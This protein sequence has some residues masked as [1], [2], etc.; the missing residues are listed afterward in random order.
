[1][2]AAVRWLC[3]KA[4]PGVQHPTGLLLLGVIT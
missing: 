4:V 2:L 1:V 3:G